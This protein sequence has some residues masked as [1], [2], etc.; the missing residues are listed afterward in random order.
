MG[1]Q[2]VLTSADQAPENVS[3]LPTAFVAK[4]KHYA[5]KPL[6][7]SENQQKFC[8]KPKHNQFQIMLNFLQRL[9]EIK[10]SFFGKTQAKADKSAKAREF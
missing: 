8:S 7:F 5:E 6:G 2:R 10:K 1:T 4:F 3:L 9:F